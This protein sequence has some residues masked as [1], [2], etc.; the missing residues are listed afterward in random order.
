MR[1]QAGELQPLAPY[2][3][4]PLCQVSSEQQVFQLIMLQAVQLE[5][6]ALLDVGFVEFKPHLETAVEEVAGWL[7]IEAQQ[8]RQLQPLLLAPFGRQRQLAALEVGRPALRMEGRQPVGG[9]GKE[10]GACRRIEVGVAVGVSGCWVIRCA[11][12]R[13]PELSSSSFSSPPARSPAAH[14]R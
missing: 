10:A 5:R 6:F 2:G 3:T 13:L 12:S 1:Q 7:A 11:S 14:S 4:V 8:L 9:I